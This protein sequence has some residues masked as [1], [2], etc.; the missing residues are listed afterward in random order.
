MVW[1]SNYSVKLEKVDMGGEVEV[2]N[3]QEHGIGEVF[4]FTNIATNFW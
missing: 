2:E 4:F 3:L 1:H